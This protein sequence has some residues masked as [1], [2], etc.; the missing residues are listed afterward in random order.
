MATEDGAIGEEDRDELEHDLVWGAAAIGG[1]INRPVRITF[2]LLE[3]GKLP[4]KKI[5]GR[6]VASRKRLL[7]D[8]VSEA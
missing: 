4:A 3:S 7:A 5:G 8:L 6:Y 1:V 2:Y